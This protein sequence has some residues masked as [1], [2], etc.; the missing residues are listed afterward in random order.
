MIT[1]K[2]R[3]APRPKDKKEL[4][5][6]YDDLPS[7]E[8]IASEALTKILTTKRMKGN[9][10]RDL[11]SE[12]QSVAGM[13]ALHTTSWDWLSPTLKNAAR[14][15]EPCMKAIA[16]ERKYLG[17][18]RPKMLQDRFIGALRRI[19]EDILTPGVKKIQTIN[20]D[21]KLTSMQTWLWWDG[22]TLSKTQEPPDA[23][24]RGIKEALIRMQREEKERLV[25]ENQDRDAINKLIGYIW[26]MSIAH[27]S[28]EPNALLSCDVV[29]PLHDLITYRVISEIGFKLVKKYLLLG[30]YISWRVLLGM[31]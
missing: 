17:T 9:Q 16:F 14:D 23:V 1:S 11:A 10:S 19:I 15:I 22:L 3:L 2:Q 29:G 4:L 21:G 28:S 6:A 27:S 25:L 24:L 7:N 26:N 20:A 31:I 8:R 5:S 13:L 12:P 18:Y 30:W